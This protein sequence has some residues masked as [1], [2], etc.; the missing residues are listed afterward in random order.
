MDSSSSVVG[1]NGLPGD[2][3]SRCSALFKFVP[4]ARDIFFAHTTWDDYVNAA[5]RTF[6]SVSMPIRRQNVKSSR[7]ESPQPRYRLNVDDVEARQQQ[8]TQAAAALGVEQNFVTFSSSPGLVASVDDFYLVGGTSR[9]TVIETSLNVMNESAYH[10]WVNPH[11]TLLSWVRNVVAN[12][13][14]ANGAGWVDLMTRFESGTYPNQWMILDAERFSPEA[15]ARVAT[16]ATE[17]DGPTTTDYDATV[18]SSAEVKR[19]AEAVAGLFTVLEE[20]PGLVH[21]EDQT[22]TLLKKGYWGSYNVA[23]YEDIRTQLNDTDPYFDCPR[24]KLFASLQ[25]SV[26]DFLQH[27]QDLATATSTTSLSHFRTSEAKCR[28]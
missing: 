24:A 28:A 20:A 14:A 17:S 1:Y 26:V 12:R 10:P 16:A 8:H 2:G 19:A 25:D 3:G 13:L 22:S 27:A 15:A 7:G 11:G 5:P 4:G 23:F 6:K 18:S 9:L 21:A